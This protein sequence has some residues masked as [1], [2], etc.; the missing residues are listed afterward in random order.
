MSELTTNRRSLRLQAAAKAAAAAVAEAERLNIDI[1][2]A[3]VDRSGDTLCLMR[4]DN[5]FFHSAGIAEDKAYTAA[6]FG[7]AT[8]QWGPVVE[9]N[10]GLEQGLAAR[11]RL[12]MFGGGLPV[13]ADDA[14]IGA[15][16]VSGGSE[17]QDIACAR[18]GLNTLAPSPQPEQ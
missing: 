11:P 9:G 15:I 14:V 2:V 7:F 12:V 8:D 6:S 10:P 5:A 17:D 18:A 16:G 1:V 3:V 13:F 4:M